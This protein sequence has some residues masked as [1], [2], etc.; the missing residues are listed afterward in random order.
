MIGEDFTYTAIRMIKHE[1][2]QRSKA[3]MLIDAEDSRHDK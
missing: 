2:E 3:M 1:K